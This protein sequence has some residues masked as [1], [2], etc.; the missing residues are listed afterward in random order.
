[1]TIG[2][3][4]AD[5]I[6]RRLL[7]FKSQALVNP[8][9]ISYNPYSIHKTLL[10]SISNHPFED[11]FIESD[12]LHFHYDFHSEL[13]STSRSELESKLKKTIGITHSFLRNAAALV[14]TYGTAWVYSKNDTH[15]IVA[16]C[17]KQPAGLFTRSLLS[18][19]HILESFDGFYKEIKKLNPQI[20]IILTVSPVRHTR[21]TLPLN[22][23]SKSVLR[24]SCHTLTEQYADVHYFP[25]YEIM[26][27]DLRDYRFYKPDMIH[28]SDEAEDY[29]WESFLSAYAQ[30]GYLDFIKKW[31]PIQQAILHKPFHPQ[32]A[33]HQI[34]LKETIR[35]L[36]EL[37]HLVNVDQE[38]D[39]LISQIID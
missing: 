37:S 27:D 28:P 38:R 5:A 21:D 1:M 35:K 24:L 8:F 31:Q 4:F 39:W 29:I 32:S 10:L 20:Q 2:S 7:S 3:C 26:I 12:G 9:G 13:V 17:H 25:A 15:A 16:N 19:K 34:F 36:E 11:N 30:P 33:G 22:S 6:G 14:I 18:Q 23:V